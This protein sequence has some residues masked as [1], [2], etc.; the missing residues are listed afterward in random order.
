MLRSMILRNHSHQSSGEMSAEDRQLVDT[1][2]SPSGTGQ[3]HRTALWKRITEAL[4]LALFLFCLLVTL[5]FVF[6]I[7]PQMWGGHPATTF[8]YTLRDLWQ[9]VLLFGVVLFILLR[10]GKSAHRLFMPVI[11]KRDRILIIGLLFLSVLVNPFITA[12]LDNF[13]IFTA[14]L[15]PVTAALLLFWMLVLTFAVCYQI[16]YKRIFHKYFTGRDLFLKK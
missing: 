15:I 10:I 4:A 14:G 13:H 5:R 6:L 9:F 3:P 1:M 11:K 12:P 7:F 16:E 2:N 8:L